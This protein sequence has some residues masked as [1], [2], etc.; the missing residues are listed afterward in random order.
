MNWLKR[1]SLIILI[2]LIFLI[3]RI[4]AETVLSWAAPKGVR[5]GVVSGTIWHGKISAFQY[6][7]YTFE[8]IR[9]EVQLSRLLT[10]KAAAKVQIG[11]QRKPSGLYASGLVY[12]GFGGP[13]ADGLTVRYPAKKMAP[14]V[15]R[16]L[17]FPMKVSATGSV[18]LKVKEYQFAK[19]LC[20]TLIGQARWDNATVAVPDMNLNLEKIETKLKC[21]KGAVVA[22]FDGK[23][24]LGLEGDVVVQDR[25]KYQAK[26]FMKPASDMP[27]ALHQGLM[28]FGKPDSQGRYAINL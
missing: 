28:F 11:S 20:E 12:Y 15:G 10:G 22:S 26:L 24:K 9:W 4:P 2:F 5:L 17:P 16:H 18:T 25:K 3:S 14:F 19:P 21:D 27:Q 13:G 7:Q 6:R 23:N 1:A 8:N